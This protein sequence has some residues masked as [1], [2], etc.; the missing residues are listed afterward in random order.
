MPQLLFIMHN[1][2]HCDTLTLLSTDT[3]TKV[4]VPHSLSPLAEDGD[5]H[6]LGASDDSGD[7]KFRKQSSVPP[8]IYSLSKLDHE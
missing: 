2:N 8:S 7:M 4:F 5:D 6:A 1:W 3:G